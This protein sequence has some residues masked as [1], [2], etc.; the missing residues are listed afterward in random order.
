MLPDSVKN[1]YIDLVDPATRFLVKHRIQP[2]LLTTIGFIINVVAAIFIFRNSLVYGGILILIGG[3]FD[4]FDG[5]VARATGL[6][7]SF[8]SFYD[9]TLDRFS[10][11]I[12]YLSLL[13]YFIVHGEPMMGHIILVAMGGALMV[14]Y[15]RARAEALD[16]TCLVGFLQRAERVLFLGFGAII[17]KG[18]LIVAIY[19]VAV[20]SVFTAIQRMFHIYVSS[21]KST[22]DE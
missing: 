1:W 5:R 21:R 14:S 13:N 7:S 4:I 22:T 10:E 2:N 6:S 8:G 16:F 19:V 15:T 20:L 17:G 11:I 18:G 9:S 3:T 12:I